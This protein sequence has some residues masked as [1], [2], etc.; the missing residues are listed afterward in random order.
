VLPFLFGVKKVGRRLL[1]TAN[2][3]RRDGG[4]SHRQHKTRLESEGRFQFT[5][6]KCHALRLLRSVA[7]VRNSLSD[8]CDVTV[9]AGA[10]LAKTRKSQV[11]FAALNSTKITSV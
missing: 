5:A 3:C 8:S 11:T 10:D 4:E 1:Q 9:K 7:L 6:E 2:A